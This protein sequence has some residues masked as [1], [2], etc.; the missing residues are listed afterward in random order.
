MSVIDVF[1]FQVKDVYKDYVKYAINNEEI[2][3]VFPRIKWQSL[4]QK[5]NILSSLK[6]N[7]P[8]WPYTV[9]VLVTNVVI[10][11]TLQVL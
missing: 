11:L 1:L 2:S 10:V 7:A 4:E 5:S 8:I 9:R 3:D 6:I